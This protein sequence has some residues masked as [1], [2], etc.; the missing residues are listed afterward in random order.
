ME[1]NEQILFSWSVTFIASSI[2]FLYSTE[3]KH[4]KLAQVGHISSVL[5]IITL[6]P[7]VLYLIW[8]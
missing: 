3:H 7:Y 4:S 5:H 1:Y 6:I 2:L 8:S